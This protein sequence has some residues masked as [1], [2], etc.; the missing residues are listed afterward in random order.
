MGGKAGSGD[1]VLPG[2][3]LETAVA[4]FTKNLQM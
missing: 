4:G 2:W 3:I 1:T